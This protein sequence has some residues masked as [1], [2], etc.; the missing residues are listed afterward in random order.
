MN[1]K[2]LIKTSIALLALATKYMSIGTAAETIN[3]EKPEILGTN[4]LIN[5]N[6]S[7]ILVP[8]KISVADIQ[9]L[10]RKQFPNEEVYVKSGIPAGDNTTL[11]ISL[12]KRG[13]PQV[14][15]GEDCLTI[16]MPLHAD[17]RV[18][19]KTENNIKFGF[20]SKRIK[21]SHH[22]D[23]NAEF[24]VFAKLKPQ[25][26]PD[27]ALDPGLDLSY[28]L[29]RG[30]NFKLGP[31]EINLVSKTRE[32]LDQHMKNLEAN[33]KKMFA[34]KIPVKKYAET[35]WDVMSTPYA[36]DEK[37]NIWAWSEPNSFHSIPMHT[38]GDVVVLGAGLSGKFFAAIQ[39]EKPD[40][41]KA[42]LTSCSQDPLPEG[43]QLNIPIKVEYERL[44][45][46][47]REEFTGKVIP[48]ASNSVTLHNYEVF[49]G[50]NGQ[51]IVGTYASFASA[52]SPISIDGWIYFCG[53]PCFDSHTGIMSISHFSFDINTKYALLN[54]FTR[55][56]PT[57]IINHVKEMLIYNMSN[58]LYD[59]HMKVNKYADN[60]QVADGI[61]LHAVV[62]ELALEKV[63]VGK[64][65]MT[66]LMISKGS[67]AIN[68]NPSKIPQTR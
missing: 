67:A 44:R 25:I 60:L 64:K 54:S 8:I 23:G 6:S 65:H 33:L 59:V 7:T 58:I 48:I 53:E 5:G 35:V 32:A 2:Y 13:E 9:S 22:E 62:K 46:L 34:E 15:P 19:W 49:G 1:A 57:G 50:T 18:D 37:A 47:L 27:Y 36:I 29:D 52:N 68:V 12:K 10:L 45:D 30:A 56:M 39:G 63:Y 21:A 43:F 3:A 11:Q 4:P 20:G 51:I 16:R 55:E 17:L 66:I 28:T 38:D 24:T 26:K 31:I 42:P 41:S 61:S 14:V 40:P